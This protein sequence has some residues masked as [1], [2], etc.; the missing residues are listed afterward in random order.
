MSESD[1]EAC[2]ADFKE[3]HAQLAAMT[4]RAE[5]AE[6]MACSDGECGKCTFCTDAVAWNDQL[7]AANARAE[8]ADK[9]AHYLAT[10]SLRLET[11]LREIGGDENQHEADCRKLVQPDRYCR[12]SA[13]VARR[14]L[15]TEVENG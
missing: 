14:A 13:G 1:H 4:K 8:A 2:D 11:A 7:R 10:Y 6:A 12:C 15:S 5:E 3:L 9:R